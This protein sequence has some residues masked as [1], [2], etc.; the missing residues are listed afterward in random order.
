LLELLIEV[1]AAVVLV[2]IQLVPQGEMAVL[3]S[4]FLS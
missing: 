4:L 3:E 1:L 2:L